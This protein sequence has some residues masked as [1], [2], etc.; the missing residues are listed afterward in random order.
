MNLLII[1][2]L[3]SNE[4][5]RGSKQS[6]ITETGINVSIQAAIEAQT[7]ALIAA[8]SAVTIAAS[9]TASN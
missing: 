4:Y 2:A 7:A 5:V 1:S 6:S 3:V 9:T 8:T